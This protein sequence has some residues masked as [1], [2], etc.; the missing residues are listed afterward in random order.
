MKDV[1]KGQILWALKLKS[2]AEITHLLFRNEVDV[3]FFSED[4]S[5]SIFLPHVNTEIPF[6]MKRNI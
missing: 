4:C 5:P 3:C 2:N 1:S 6:L